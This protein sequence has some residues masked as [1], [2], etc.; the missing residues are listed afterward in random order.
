MSFC[1]E[2]LRWHDFAC[3]ITP[4]TLLGAYRKHSDLVASVTNVALNAIMFLSTVV[5]QI[6]SIFPRIAFTCLSFTGMISMNMQGSDWIKHVRDCRF[7]IH[8]R[9]FVPVMLTAARVCVKAC[10]IFLTFSTFGAAVI[11]LCGF[12]HISITIFV[13]LQPLALLALI[14]T[15]FGELIDYYSNTRLLNRLH[16]VKKEDPE[17]LVA[18]RVAQCFVNF[19]FQP[20]FQKMDS[21][22]DRNVVWKNPQRLAF[23][24]LAQM[25]EWD[26]NNLKEK[27]AAAGIGRYSVLSQSEGLWVFKKVGKSLQ[28]HQTMTKA[29]IGL[30][31]LGY[32]SMGLCRLFPQTIIQY[33]VTL[34]MSLLYTAKLAYRKAVK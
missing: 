14:G 10:N 27:L 11:A 1:S 32:V 8:L 30:I 23:D 28:H 6:P 17:G 13:V 31:V 7:A 25:E 21:R 29:N 18:Q 22:I 19:A 34:G 5:R 24:V 26:L 9:F 2:V 33:G 4:A 15:I 12:P 20:L 3:S 16:A